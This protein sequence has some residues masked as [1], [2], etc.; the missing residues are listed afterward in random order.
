MMVEVI[1]EE[2]A[3]EQ[4]MHGYCMFLASALHHQYGFPIGLVS[5]QH[6]D[7]LRLSHAWVVK[8]GKCLDIQGFQTLEEMTD[9]MGDA[10]EA[11]Y[12]LYEKTDLAHLEGLAGVSLPADEK[13]VKEALRV[14][15]FYLARELSS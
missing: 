5:I 7:K 3:V 6:E 8:D 2:D 1:S 12:K 9:F 11:V 10:P 15:Q 4:Y 14:A 13:D